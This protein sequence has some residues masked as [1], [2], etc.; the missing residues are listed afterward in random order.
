MIVWVHKV[1]NRTVIVDS[2]W[3][4]NN[5]CASHLQTQS[6]LYHIS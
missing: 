1:L 2:D 5:L 6:E 3:R 4:F